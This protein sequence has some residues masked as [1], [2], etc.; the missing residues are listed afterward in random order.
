MSYTDAASVAAFLGVTL[1]AGQ[2]AEATTEAAAASVTID[3]RTGRSWGSTP[4]TTITGEQHTLTGP[5]LYLRQPPVSAITLVTMRW[6]WAGAPLLTLLAG[7][8]YELV[9][10]TLGI[11]VMRRSYDPIAGAELDVLRDDVYG[12]LDRIISVDYTS[13]QGPPAD[14]KRAATLLVAV[15]LYTTLTASRVGENRTEETAATPAY[16]PKL[17]VEEADKLIKAARRPVVMA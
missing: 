4:P 2:T 1:T 5:S 6:Q 16:D 13:S 8:D 11:V 7:T 15:S 9:D 12:R 10:A 3:R 17:W 14:I